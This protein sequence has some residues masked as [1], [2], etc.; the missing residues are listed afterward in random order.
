MHT[1][2]SRPARQRKPLLPV[3]VTSH[4]EPGVMPHDLLHGHAILTVTDTNKPEAEREA[5]YWATALLSDGRI[6]AL[7]LQK[8]GRKLGE[9]HHRVTLEPLSCDCEDA[10]WRPGR[11]G[12]CRHVNAV[13]QALLELA[14]RPQQAVANE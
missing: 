9:D 11:P 5:F 4:F 2:L 6:V 12:G 7:D 1:T 10:T 13:R 3:N 8:F 14:C